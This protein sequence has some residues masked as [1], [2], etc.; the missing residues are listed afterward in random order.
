MPSKIEWTD[1]TWNPVT[2]CTKV[3]EGCRNCYAERMAKRLAGRFGYPE[4]PHHFDVTLHPDK[5]DLP[6]RWKKPR[7]VF[8]CSMGDL[9]HQDIP[10]GFIYDVFKTMGKAPQH[11]FQILT[12]RPR[13]MRD[14][15]YAWSGGQIFANASFAKLHPN[16]WLGVS[17]ENQAAA[18]VRREYLRQCP[19]AAKFVSYEPALGPVDWDGWE[20]V[21]Q[22][23]SGNESGLGARP[24]HPDWHR[25]ARDWCQAHGIKYFFKQ[26]GRYKEIQFDKRDKGDMLVSPT[27]GVIDHLPDPWEHPEEFKRTVA[28]SPVGK[29]AAGRILDN[30]T[31]SEMPGQEAEL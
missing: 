24:G 19:A 14:F 23:I 27:R 31:W 9:F 22:I 28:M 10:A 21:D 11:T 30:R 2:G 16:I 29:K 7:M 26:W 25:G 5:L 18:D 1:E 13:R 15:V 3:S 17:A 6:L 12:K 8:V 4:Q 20:F